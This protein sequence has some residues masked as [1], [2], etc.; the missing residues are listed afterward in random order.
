MG[1]QMLQNKGVE[2]SRLECEMLLSH[3]LGW[4]RHELYLQKD[5]PLTP[6]QLQ[7]YQGMLQRRLD[8]EPIQYITGTRAFMGLSFHV[9][10]RVLIPRWETELLTEYVLHAA[11][12]KQ[13]PVTI[14]DLGTG[15]GVIAVSLAVNL[16][17]ANIIAIDIREDALEVARENAK[18]NG[19]LGRI[20]FHHGD[21]F[22][23]LEPVDFHEYFDMI[24]SNPPYIPTGDIDDL[25]PEVREHEPVSALDGGADGLFFYR[26]IAG[27]AWRYLKDDGLIAMEMGYGQSSSIQE[28][29]LETGAYHGQEVHKDLAEIDRFAVFHKK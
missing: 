13:P 7:I 27:E 1:R 3:I 22:A 16:P 29:F 18:N 19:V 15:S 11:Q 25:M 28:L 23:P 24:V 21:L 2:C 10:N 26:K 9:D 20:E 14:L 12:K 6:K 17:R 8:G 5:R 4:Q